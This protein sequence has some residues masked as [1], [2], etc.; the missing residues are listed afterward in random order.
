MEL[1]TSGIAGISSLTPAES[2]YPKWLQ[3]QLAKETA[4]FQK[5]YKAKN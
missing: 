2:P 5:E 4:D 3:D 1:L